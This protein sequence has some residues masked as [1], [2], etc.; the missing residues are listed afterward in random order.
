MPSET[1]QL[2]NNS[3]LEINSPERPTPGHDMFE[4]VPLPSPSFLYELNN[5]LTRTAEGRVVT[6][7]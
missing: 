3:S 5:Q 4:C 6:R 2:K 7:T 1:S